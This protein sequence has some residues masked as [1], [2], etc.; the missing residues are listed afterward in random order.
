MD[1]GKKKNIRMKQKN[2]EQGDKLKIRYIAVILLLLSFRSCYPVNGGHR[3]AQS[4][5]L[6]KSDK[7]YFDFF[8][9]TIHLTDSS[10]TKLSVQLLVDGFSKFYYGLREE[11]SALSK[12]SYKFSDSLLTPYKNNKIEIG[13]I[14]EYNKIYSLIIVPTDW[15]KQER[16]YGFFRQY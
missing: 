11:D 14:S 4:Y 5:T 6:V 1:A 12:S 9:N 10:K 7:V 3:G 2:K 15:I 16:V 8:S 13:V